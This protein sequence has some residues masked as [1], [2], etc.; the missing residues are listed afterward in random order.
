[1]TISNLPEPLRRDVE[2]APR[3]SPGGGSPY[4][5]AQLSDGLRRRIA[6]HAGLGIHVIGTLANL[7][8]DEILLNGK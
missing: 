1:M 5:F 3:C 8:T 4:Q 6:D 7:T 2:A